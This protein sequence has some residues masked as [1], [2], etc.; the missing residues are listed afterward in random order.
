MALLRTRQLGRGRIT[1][2][3]MR[4]ITTAF[5]VVPDGYRA[6]VREVRLTVTSAPP[7]AKTLF[8]YIPASGGYPDVNVW[9]GTV[10]AAMNIVQACQ[11]VLHGGSGLTMVCELPRLDWVVSGALLPEL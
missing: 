10:S 8:L 11:L 1:N 4:A 5:F 2:A 3:E 7:A 6:V 9:S